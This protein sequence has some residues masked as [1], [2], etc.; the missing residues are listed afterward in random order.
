VHGERRRFSRPGRRELFV[1]NVVRDAYQ[2]LTKKTCSLDKELL[3]RLHAVG[4][5]TDFG[6]DGTG[7]HMKYLRQGGGYYIN[8]GCSDL[9]ADRKIRLAH[10]RDVVRFT[11]DGMQMSDGSTIAADVVVLATGYERQ[12]DTLRRLLGDE[13]AAKV[14]DVWGFDDQGFM[15]NMWRPTAQDHLWLM[16]ALMECR[17]FSRFLAL[18]LKADLEGILPH[19]GDRRRAPIG[20]A[21]RATAPIAGLAPDSLERANR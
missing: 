19:P 7:F 15:K 13:V 14:D 20:V 9:I 5:E 16:G 10:A 17:L 21:S 8:V 3:D 6:D 11:P 2:W 12:S 4:F 1:P 18:Q